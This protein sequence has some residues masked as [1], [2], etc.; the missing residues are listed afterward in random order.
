MTRSNLHELLDAL[1]EIRASEY[2][3]ISPEIIAQIVQAQFENQDDRAVARNKTMKL[4]AD[5]L[6]KETG[7]GQ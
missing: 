7:G 4:I 3:D 6:K 1:E 2:P 5:Y